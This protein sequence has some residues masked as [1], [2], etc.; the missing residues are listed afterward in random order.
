[1]GDNDGDDVDGSSEG[2]SE[3]AKDILGL[4][5]GWGP[6]TGLLVGD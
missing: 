5:D 2:T 3:G 4:A 6:S 1:V